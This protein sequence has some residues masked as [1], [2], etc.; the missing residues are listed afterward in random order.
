M[1]NDIICFLTTLFNWSCSLYYNILQYLTSS[2]KLERQGK[3][4]EKES[5][6]DLKE[7]CQA[8]RDAIIS[9]L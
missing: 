3:K 2:S 9:S 8:D 5:D 7:V 4:K 6:R 1:N